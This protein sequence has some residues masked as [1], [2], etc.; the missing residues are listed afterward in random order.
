MTRRLA[1]AAP[2]ATA[3]RVAARPKPITGIEGGD[4]VTTHFLQVD[5]GYSGTRW[6][7]YTDF[8]AETSEESC[9]PKSLV[10]PVA[11]FI[12]ISLAEK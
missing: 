11:R 10:D 3:L 12:V 4:E 8:I 7:Q 6:W 2:A 1:A 9:S 5:H